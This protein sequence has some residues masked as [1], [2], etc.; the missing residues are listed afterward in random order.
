MDE[1]AVFYG[2]FVGLVLLL[3]DFVVQTFNLPLCLLDCRCRFSTLVCGIQALIQRLQ[4]QWLLLKTFSK[5]ILQDFALFL[6]CRNGV[7]KG[8]DTKNTFFFGSLKGK[9]YLCN[10]FFIV[11]DLR[12]TRLGYSGIPF[13]FPFRRKTMRH[14]FFL[15]FSQ[16][17]L[18]RG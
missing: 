14:S 7:N 15:P 16:D 18:V 10:V 17:V 11:L 9:S 6:Y 3:C 2:L 4:L 12:L 13:F 8:G 1:N 5:M